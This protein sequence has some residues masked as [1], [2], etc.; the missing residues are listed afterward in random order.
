MARDRH[1][2]TGWSASSP[3]AGRCGR[4]YRRAPAAAV[5]SGGPAPRCR[6][7]R[8]AAAASSAGAAPRPGTRPRTA[9]ATM[10]SRA[11][12]V[13]STAA[14]RSSATTGAPAGSGRKCRGRN[15]VS[16]MRGTVCISGYRR[17]SR[18]AHRARPGLPSPPAPAGS[19]R[20]DR[21]ACGIDAEHAQ[22]L[23]QCRRVRGVAGIPRVAGGSNGGL[24][25]AALG[26]RGRYRGA[27]GSRAVC[28]GDLRRSDRSRLGRRGGACRHRRP[29]D[30]APRPARP[31]RPRCC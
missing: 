20:R 13:S 21:P 26:V 30:A 2:A 14:W 23:G 17:S 18:S 19:A 5:R 1:K 4:Q 11:R 31:P 3:A 7:S 6:P 12:Q 16:P 28:R 27:A 25:F 10:T 22:R 29:A 8:R 15:G 9:Q 24:R